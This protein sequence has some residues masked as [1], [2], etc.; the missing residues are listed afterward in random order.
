MTL[1]QYIDNGLKVYT[2]AQERSDSQID[3]E[4]IRLEEEYM[5]KSQGD[6]NVER[7]K[8]MFADDPEAVARLEAMEQGPD[9]FRRSLQ[10]Q[11][12]RT[13]N[14]AF[15][16]AMEAQ[17]KGSNFPAVSAMLDVMS[18]PFR[19]G[20]ALLA[21]ADPTRGEVDITDRMG[22]AQTGEFIPDAMRDPMNVFM[23]A[24][25]GAGA[26]SKGVGRMARPLLDKAGYYRPLAEKL[27]TG[28]TKGAMEQLPYS[29]TGQLEQME[30]G[31]DFSPSEMGTELAVGS[32]LPMAGKAVK[33]T[34]SYAKNFTKDF[35]SESTNRTRELL[36]LVGSKPAKQSLRQ[37]F[38]TDKSP[39]QTL[40]DLSDFAGGAEQVAKDI[41]E[42]IDN[43]DVNYRQNNEIV[44]KAINEM[45]DMDAGNLVAQLENSKMLLPV[46]ADPKAYAKDIS[47]NDMIDNQ[48]IKINDRIAKYNPVGTMSS[49]T[50]LKKS[51]FIPAKEMLDIRREMDKGIDYDVNTFTKAYADPIFK[52]KK[53]A[54]GYIREELVKNAESIG[55]KEYANAMKEFHKLLK[56]QDQAKKKLLPR[57]DD[58]G[59]V[60]RSKNFL[61]RLGNPNQLDARKW[62]KEFGNITGMDLLES[63]D[64]LKLSK[65]YNGALPLINDYRTGAKT[66]GVEALRDVPIA[67]QA[68]GAA[69][70]S[71]QMAGNIYSGLNTASDMLGGYS[72]MLNKMS[73]MGTQ[74]EIGE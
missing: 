35:L 11:G 5:S 58:L 49:L 15:P 70:S 66:F 62:A 16:R 26:I 32:F 28:T 57:V 21:K 65:E 56:M 60:D 61:L 53:N 43:L 54:T 40:K 59:E 50:G 3:R 36:E 39:D 1:E 10:S 18:Y 4:A 34:L 14:A 23:G 45:P 31:Q 55:N 42:K 47:F 72:P 2:T 17:K 6:R 22:Q 20:E 13:A 64:L 67:G 69:A 63:G 37:K 7:A 8:K 30:Q 71:P 68:L 73:Q 74:R 38:T 12:L 41:V 24:G 29:L 52:L 51:S 19:A 33:G 27:A 9:A 44:D 48:I 25:S 46:N